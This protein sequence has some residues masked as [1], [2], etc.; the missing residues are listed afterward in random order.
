MTLP[1]YDISELRVLLL[2]DNALTQRLVKSI[3][4]SFQVRD[5]QMMEDGAAGMKLLKHSEVDII[6]CDFDMKLMNGIEFIKEVRRSKDE[7]IQTI[8]I[9]M[10]TGYTE[11]H[12]VV[13]ALNS[14]V[15]EFLAKPIAPLQLYKR[16][17]SIID[18]PRTFIRSATFMGPDR[19]RKNTSY[20]GEERRGVP[21]E[22]AAEDAVS[23]E[24]ED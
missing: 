18:R 7:H 15:N 10:L 16:F 23:P 8:P 14:G 1:A 24:P 3:L 20:M 21:L 13:D 11:Q 12:R 5:L 9:I 22:G 2:E 4:K 17:V 6:V 19:R